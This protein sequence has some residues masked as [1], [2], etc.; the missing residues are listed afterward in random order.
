MDT[1]YIAAIEI[2]SSKIKGLIAS[3]GELGDITLLAA[4]EIKVSNCVRYGRISNVQEVT[5]H[6]NRIIRKL[7]NSPAVSPGK[8]SAV[9]LALGGR[10]FATMAVQASTKL[11]S[12]IEIT[13]DTVERLKREASFGLVVTDKET[14]ALLPKTFNVDNT[15]VKNVVGTIG[16]QIKAEF[17]ALVCAP[18]NKRNLERI[19]IETSE[20]QPKREY[21]YRPIAQADLVLSPDE[22]QIGC[23]LV[24]FGAETTTVSVYK[25]DVLQAIVTLP[26]G[27]RNITRDL[28][29]GLSMTEENAEIAKSSVGS[30]MNTGTETD[31][32]KVEI[33]NYIQARA[34][35]IIANIVHQIEA[36]GFKG[37]DLPGGLIFIGGGAKLSNF[38]KLAE[39]QT[40]MPVRAGKINSSITVKAN[41]IDLNENIDIIAIAKYAAVNSD[42]NCITRPVVAEPD[43][44]TD[45]EVYVARAGNIAR[46]TRRSISEDD[47]NLLED[48]YDDDDDRHY[49]P[50]K[51][52]ERRQMPKQPVDDIDEVLDG[53]NGEDGD[54]DGDS[55]DTEGSGLISR[56]NKVKERLA[57]FFA[58][59]G[60]GDNLDEPTE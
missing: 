32:A 18:D 17:L 9:Y 40:K 8:V 1:R 56:I 23:A 36:V 2:G 7:E 45:D 52:K 4:E 35:E 15:E 10:S 47:E 6:V 57:S 43:D 20:Q 19:K 5:L 48:D 39:A 26:M 60:A 16:S 29:V 30:A 51:K 41:G 21:I 38:L 49:R 44:D 54:R 25:N 50:K 22:R 55:D 58:D 59:K 11:P 12:A 34:G 3:V 14:L 13:A 24:D 27:S 42:L 31:N 28:M 53:D 37:Q 33:N 46:G